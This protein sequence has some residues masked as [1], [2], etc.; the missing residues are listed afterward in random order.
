LTKSFVK[1]F[2][3]CE[4]FSLKVKDEHVSFLFFLSDLL[5][6]CLCSNI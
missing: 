4:F 6:F 3:P 1:E 2:R 5:M